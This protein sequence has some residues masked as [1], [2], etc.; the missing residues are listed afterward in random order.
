MKGTCLFALLFINVC[1][2]FSQNDEKQVRAYLK[3][4]FPNNLSPA[5]VWFIECKYKQGKA[6]Q[7]LIACINSVN[8]KQLSTLLFAE[9]VQDSMLLIEPFHFAS[10]VSYELLN[11]DASKDAVQELYITSVTDSGY[12][13]KKLT[14]IYSCKNATIDTLITFNSF[15]FKTLKA[16]YFTYKQGII[17]EEESI[18][19]PGDIDGDGKIDIINRIHRTLLN[20][21]PKTGDNQF[22]YQTEYGEYKYIKGKYVKTSSVEPTG[23]EEKKDDK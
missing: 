21:E 18:C 3:E 1:A 10:V 19:K 12:L 23:E 20:K 15:K 7:Y 6:W 22:E 16:P 5:K 17:V 9:R 2:L 4:Q 11:V 13:E 8:Q 14:G